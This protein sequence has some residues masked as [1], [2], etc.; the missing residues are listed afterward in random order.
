M[1]KKQIP[2]PNTYN[3][4]HLKT[5]IISWLMQGCSRTEI[6]KLI[7]GHS[8]SKITNVEAEKLLTESKTMLQEN[9][10]TETNEE[11]IALHVGWYEEIYNY[12]HSIQHSEGMRRSLAAKEKL[13]GLTQPEKIIVNKNTQVSVQQNENYDMQKLTEHERERLEFLIKKM[14]VDNRE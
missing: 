2:T 6:L 11:T 14:T 1:I 5:M 13:I 3:Q 8:L 12:F 7:K 10:A 4:L 9:V